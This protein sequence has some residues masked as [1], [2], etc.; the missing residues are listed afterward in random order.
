MLVLVGVGVGYCV[1]CVLG[2]VL[3]FCFV[4]LV[5]LVVGLLGGGY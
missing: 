1:C 3:G 4:F 2:S 5:R